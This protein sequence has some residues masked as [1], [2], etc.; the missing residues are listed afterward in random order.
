MGESYRRPYNQSPWRPNPSAPTP[1]L[2]EAV[3]AIAAREVDRL[4]R[5]TPASPEYQ[6]IRAYIELPPEVATG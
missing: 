5:M 2:P 1:A 6:M 3:A 4:E